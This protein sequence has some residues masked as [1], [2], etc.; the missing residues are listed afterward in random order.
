M[1]HSI[2]ASRGCT[3][4]AD[5]LIE[6]RIRN[7]KAMRRRV[8]HEMLRSRGR[9]EKRSTWSGVV[10]KS[11]AQCQLWLVSVCQRHGVWTRTPDIQGNI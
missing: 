6:S 8:V 7:D 5:V 9:S 3:E 2:I 10:G 4:I 1:A 11:I